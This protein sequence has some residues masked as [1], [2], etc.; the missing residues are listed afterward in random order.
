MDDRYPDRSE[1][2]RLQ[3]QKLNTVLSV[4]AKR[5]FYQ[6]RL[7]NIQLPLRSLDELARLPLLTKADLQGERAG[8]PAKVFDESPEQY[9]RFHQTSGSSGHPLPV[10]DTA[11]DWSWWLDCWNHVL[12]AT[13]VTSSDVA[14]MAFSFG[15]FIGFWT[16][17]D[18]LSQ[19]GALVVPGGGMSSETRLRMI[20]DHRCTLVCCTPT[21]ALHLARVADKLR[22]DLASSAVRALIVA[23]EPG[24]SHPIIRKQIED[25]WQ[26]RVVDHA[27]ASEVGAWGFG[28]RMGHGLFVIET[29]FIAELLVFDDEHPHGRLAQLGHSTAADHAGEVAELVLTNLGRLGGPAI[30]YRTGD[31]VRG[32]RNHEW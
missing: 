9:V 23:G 26:A 7:A 5:P 10:M 8:T 28:D 1:I 22:L 11:K 20:L 29:E 17:N 12:D 24:G 30:R 3:L 15:P 31:L 13:E 4:A 21:Y 14:M 19:R 16:A 18:A 2:E 32:V 25:A 6:A 27:G